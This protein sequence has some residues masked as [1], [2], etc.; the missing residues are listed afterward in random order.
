VAGFPDAS[1]RL[2]LQAAL[3]QCQGRPEVDFR[4]SD[5]IGAW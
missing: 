2:H 1:F 5:P 3:S 4:E